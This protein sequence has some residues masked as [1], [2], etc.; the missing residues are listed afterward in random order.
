MGVDPLAHKMP[1]WSPYSYTFN[2]PIRFID[3]DGR[4]P[5][6]VKPG[7]AAALRAIKNTLS[8]A[9]AAYVKLD[10]NGNINRDILNLRTMSSSGNFA[11]LQELVNSETTY[12]I[13]IASSYES[14]DVEGAQPLVGDDQNGTKG[15][16]LFPGAENDRSPDNDVHVFTSDKLSP[17]RQA[18]NLSH[19]AYGHAYFYE[20]KQQGQDVNPNHQYEATMIEVNPNADNVFDR[21]ALGRKDVNTPLVNQIKAREKEAVQNFNNRD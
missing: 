14:A 10:A 2:N 12:H 21:Y 5:Q 6:T 7:S 4:A 1:A 16:T 13:N 11:A 9:D 15:V 17:E 19:E 8:S 20:L 3:P 18:E